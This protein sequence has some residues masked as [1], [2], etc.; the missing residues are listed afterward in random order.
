MKNKYIAEVKKY[1]SNQHAPIDTNKLNK[2]IKELIENYID[3]YKVVDIF[4]DENILSDLIEE[5]STFDK[6]IDK[7]YLV[8]D[9]DQKSFTEE[10][11]DNIVEK[12]KENDI[13][14]YVINP[15]FEFWLLLHFKDCKEYSN[16]QLIDNNYV[17]TGNTFVYEELKKCD[18]SYTKSKF[19]ASLYMKKLDTA[20]ENSK[21]YE[22]DI[23]AL[24]KKIGTNICL[25]LEK[26][27]MNNN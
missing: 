13:H 11:Y 3:K 24:K 14:F 18:P 6:D 27:M 19:N 4:H 16:E 7:I 26:L 23:I 8:V 1:E 21:I 9:R 15:C 12:T 17:K 20:I 22:T 25:L 10:Q 2:I 5:Q